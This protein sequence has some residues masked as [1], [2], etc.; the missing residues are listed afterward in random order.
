M[1]SPKRGN[2]K[3]KNKY[4]KLKKEK[5]TAGFIGITTEHG[6]TR[7]KTVHKL[8]SLVGETTQKEEEGPK[9]K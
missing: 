7:Y 8:L 3:K 1:P 5:E 9:C 4:K 2:K 6:L